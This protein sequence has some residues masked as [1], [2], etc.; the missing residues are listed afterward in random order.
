MP[1]D[2]GAVCYFGLGIE[3]GQ[4]I[5]IGAEWGDVEGLMENMGGKGGFRGGFP[6]GGRGGPGD[7]PPGGGHGGSRPR[8]PRRP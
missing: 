3:P 4:I 5:S 1:L 8:A 2:E 6:G 7:K